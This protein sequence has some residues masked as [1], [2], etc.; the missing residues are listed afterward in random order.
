MRLSTD[1]GAEWWRD[2]SKGGIF[3][4]PDTFS[5]A[6]WDRALAISDFLDGLTFEPSTL[7]SV[8]ELMV[9]T[10]PSPTDLPY[11]GT[12]FLENAYSAMGED[13]L[14]LLERSKLSDADKEAV[15]SGF[16]L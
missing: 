3:R 16:R 7:Q 13:A 4:V 6:R 2:H 15:R 1:L 14:H 12:W 5:D 10:A 9:D 11:V 8:L